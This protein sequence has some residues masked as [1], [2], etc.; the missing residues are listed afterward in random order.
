MCQRIRRSSPALCTR[1]TELNDLVATAYAWYWYKTN[2]ATYLNEGDDL[3]SNVWNSANGQ[4]IGGDSGW[5]YSVKEFNQIYKWSFDY[6]R[7]RSGKNPDGS[8]PPVETRIAGCQSVRHNSHPCNSPW[9][10]YTTPVQFEWVAGD[11]GNPPSINPVLTLPIVSPTTATIYLS[12]FK[13]N[14]T[15]TVYYGTAAPGTCDINN[16]QPPN[17]MQ[18]YPNFGFL[19]MLTANY[20]NQTQPVTD[21]LDQH[22]LAQGIPNV[23]DASVTITGLTPNTIY[24]ARYLTTDSL[25][26]HGSLL[27]SGIFTSADDQVATP[28]TDD[29]GSSRPAARASSAPDQP[30]EQPCVDP[31]DFKA[32]QGIVDSRLISLTP[33]N[34]PS[35]LTAHCAQP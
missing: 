14:T 29:P 32:G 30:G 17:C 22:A 27:R 4:T 24:H 23:Y 3:F 8:S 28:P 13:P 10:D 7:W 11:N 6:V 16:P 35:S 2:N 5:T 33:S 1:P 34:I 9:T 25:G 19:N 12:V 31:S 20:A 26:K 15:L 18:P 21:Y